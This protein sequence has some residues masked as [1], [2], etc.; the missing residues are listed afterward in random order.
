MEFSIIGLDGLFPSLD[1]HFRSEKLLVGWWV[2]CRIIVSAPVPV[3][4]L[5]TL[6]FGFGTGL[7]F[8]K[9]W[10]QGPICQDIW[11]LKAKPDG[12]DLFEVADSCPADV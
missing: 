2:A 3:P 7:G 1:L 5:W 12:W 9:Y 6:D 11:W 10:V 4:F 8:D